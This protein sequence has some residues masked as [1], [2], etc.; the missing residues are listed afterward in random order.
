MST[1]TSTTRYR[2]DPSARFRVLDDEGIFVLQKA[3]EVLVVNR[4]GAFIVERLRGGMA[5]TEIIDE[6]VSA[7]D[8]DRAR[9][10]EDAVTLL[11]SLVEAGALAEA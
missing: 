11:D 6:V 3:G 7:Y 10:E 5:L 2:L 1:R 4:V 8:V 9:A